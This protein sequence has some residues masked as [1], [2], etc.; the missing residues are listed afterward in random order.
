M[1]IYILEMQYIDYGNCEEVDIKN[2]YMLPN[3]LA[4]VSPAARSVKVA[5]TRFALDSEENRN[6][7]LEVLDEKD[8]RVMMMPNLMCT[9]SVNGEELKMKKLLK[10]DGRN[11]FQIAECCQVV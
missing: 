1:L 4:E 7:L 10:V 3:S 6:F 2:I 9:F 11:L 8:V 5:G